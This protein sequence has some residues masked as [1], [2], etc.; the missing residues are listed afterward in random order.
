M[1]K[2]KYENLLDFSKK[3]LDTIGLDQFSSN[4][5]SE[6][7][8]ETSLRG[9]DSHGIRLLPHYINSAL[10]GRKNPNPNF[11]WENKYPSIISLDAD[12]AFGHA[13]GIK[14]VEIGLEAANRYGIAAVAVKNSTHPGAL[15]CMTLKAAR[16]GY[17]SIGFT[18][19]D[20]LMLSHN[21]TRP[22]F[23]TNPISV[24]VPRLEKE[25][26]CLDMATTMISWNKLLNF[27][28]KEKQIEN[29]IA[30]NQFGDSVSDPNEASSL[31]PAGSY[32]GFGL[33]SVVEIFCGVYNGM[34]FGR[35]IPAMFTTPIEL[36]RHLGQF[37]IFLKTDGSIQNE[38]F[39]KAMQNLSDEVRSEPMKNEIP[40]QMP[41][42][43][44][45]KTSTDRLKNGIPLDEDLYKTFN[46]LVIDYKINIKLLNI[47]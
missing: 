36:K 39:L 47:S 17:I 41:N 34:A 32:K 16:Q 43:P 44:E 23:G 27:R 25:P 40:V 2:V 6:G 30:A 12:N 46:D 10:S 5:V 4:A 33:A 11:T 20:S 31:F 1:I 26:Y 45:I 42:D 35:D 21:G 13:A 15:S 7:L 9:V 24:A 18:H 14:A 37:Y 28:K 19:A 29:D 8:C 3:I 22:Y 38:S